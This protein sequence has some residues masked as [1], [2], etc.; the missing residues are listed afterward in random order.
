MARNC[1]DC[2]FCGS[3][4]NYDK[5]IGLNSETKSCIKEHSDEFNNNNI[6][7]PFYKKA[8]T[9]FYTE[10]FGECVEQESAKEKATIEVTVLGDSE[11]HFM[12]IPANV[13]RK[14]M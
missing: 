12:Y 11:R 14:D 7:C 5:E 4:Y 3:N 9:R 6:F 10:S 13:Q 8:E 1:K 2:S